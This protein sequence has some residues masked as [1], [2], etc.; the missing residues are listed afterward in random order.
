MIWLKVK[1]WNR[2]EIKP[3]EHRIGLT[4]TPNWGASALRSSRSKGIHWKRRF[5]LLSRNPLKTRSRIRGGGD[6][7]SSQTI[8]I[9]EVEEN[10]EGSTSERLQSINT[11]A[12]LS[13]KDSEFEKLL[14]KFDYREK[15]SRATKNRLQNEA[16]RF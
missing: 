16:N 3:R 1:I 8:F 7:S 14:F 4:H 5:L 15:V 12:Y 13:I 9:P 2:S 10:L 11:K 6:A